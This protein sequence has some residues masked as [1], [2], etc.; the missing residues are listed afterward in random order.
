MLTRWW[1]IYILAAIV[2]SAISFDIVAVR[3]P[4]RNILLV[5]CVSVAVVQLTM[6]NLQYYKTNVAYPLYDPAPVSVAIQDI[7]KNAGSLPPIIK[8]GPPSQTPTGQEGLIAWNRNDGLLNGTSALPC[9]EALFGYSYEYFPARGLEV[10]PLNRSNSDLMN[11]ADPRCYFPSGNNA[12]HPGDQFHSEDESDAL[13]FAAHRPLPWKE[14]TWQ[15]TA[16]ALT[17]VSI[18]LSSGLLLTFGIYRLFR[19]LASRIIAH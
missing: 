15:R 4:M 5:G 14:P 17:L 18:S 11:M 3:E 8:L 12:C 13:V 9:Y 16:R 1:S 10:G 6:R 2:L 19:Q 7:V